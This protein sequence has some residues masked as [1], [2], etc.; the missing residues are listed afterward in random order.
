MNGLDEVVFLQADV[1]AAASY[2]LEHAHTFC[3]QQFKKS[4]ESDMARVAMKV[5]V[6]AL[7]TVGLLLT[8]RASHAGPISMLTFTSTGVTTDQDVL[9]A[10][11][12]PT[13]N[14]LLGSSSSGTSTGPNFVT[15]H[16]D[17]AGLSVRVVNNVVQLGLSMTS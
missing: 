12:S 14:L 4:G 10:I 8:A 5:S 15:F 13:T 6:S 7:V 16:S 2:G 1:N 9:A 11:L 17:G 3:Q